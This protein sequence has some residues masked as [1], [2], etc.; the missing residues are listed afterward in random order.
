MSERGTWVSSR[1]YC[2]AC[3]AG[4]TRFLDSSGAHFPPYRH[5]SGMQFAPGAFVGEMGGL[6]AGQE[7][8]DWEALLPELQKQ[9]CHPLRIAVLADEGEKVYSLHPSRP[10]T[11]CGAHAPETSL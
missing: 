6:Y 7:L 3:I 11:P 10:T 1:M 9:I 8:H 5:W 4:F 2:K